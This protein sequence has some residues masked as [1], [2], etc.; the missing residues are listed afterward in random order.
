MADPNRSRT[1]FFALLAQL[2][3]YPANAL[4]CH[5]LN[6]HLLPFLNP[7]T[8]RSLWDQPVRLIITDFPWQFDFA[9]APFGFRPL[10]GEMP[11]RVTFTGPLAVYCALIAQEEDSDTLFF[12]RRLRVSGD[13]ALGLFIKN[14]L[15]ALP[16]EAVPALFFSLYPKC[17]PWLTTP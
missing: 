4:F 1:P 15:D 8:R 9:L 16:R 11:P 17:K 12:Q 3:R 7:E 2:P 14:T 10:T 5:A 6:R 13:T